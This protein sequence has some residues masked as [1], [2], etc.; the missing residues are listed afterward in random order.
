[1]KTPCALDRMPTAALR[2]FGLIIIIM[3]AIRGRFG[4]GRAA[5][6]FEAFN[7]LHKTSD[8]TFFSP[9]FSN[10]IVSCCRRPLH[11]VAVADSGE[12]TAVVD[13]ESERGRW[14]SRPC[15]H[16][17]PRRAVA[18]DPA[19]LAAE[20]RDDWASRSRRCPDP[21][22]PLFFSALACARCQPAWCSWRRT[23][24]VVAR[25]RRR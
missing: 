3:H 18:G 4:R 17:I 13:R 24:R 22:P 11:H 14:T 10:A 5:C 20:S 2:F 21:P 8:A 6:G 23:D 1:M 16:S 15:R 12:N 25:A 9:A 19:G 7:P